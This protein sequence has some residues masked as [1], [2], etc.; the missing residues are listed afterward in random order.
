MAHIITAR[1]T[2]TV[3]GKPRWFPTCSCGWVCQATR[4]TVAEAEKFGNEK[5]TG[6]RRCPTPHKK[7][8][9]SRQ[10]AERGMRTFWRTAGKGKKMPCRVYEC[11]CKAW[12]T[13]AL[14][15]RTREMSA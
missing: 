12:H 1:E 9:P 5:H 13:T 11:D 8:F 4:K 10:D 14:P 6:P 2:A 15:R 3:S 7:R